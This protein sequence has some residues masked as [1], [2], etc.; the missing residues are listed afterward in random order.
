[1]VRT[2]MLYADLEFSKA[3]IALGGPRV[4]K[5]GRMICHL[6]AGCHRLLFRLQ[7]TSISPRALEEWA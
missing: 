6:K 7:G 3:C 5:S 1:M 4:G 2:I